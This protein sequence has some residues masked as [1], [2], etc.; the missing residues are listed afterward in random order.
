MIKRIAIS[1]ILLGT[2][3]ISSCGENIKYTEDE[4]FDLLIGKTQRE[5]VELI[6]PPQL[7]DSNSW[8]YGKYSHKIMWNPITEQ[9]RDFE[10]EFYGSSGIVVSVRAI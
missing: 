2:F 1:S 7:E 5:V 9:Y 8:L 4:L 6:G 3:I 10:V